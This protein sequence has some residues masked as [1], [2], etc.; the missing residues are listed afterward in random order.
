MVSIPGESLFQH[1]AKSLRVGGPDRRELE[2]HRSKADNASVDKFSEPSYF[3]AFQKIPDA[4]RDQLQQWARRRTS[5]YRLVVRSRIVLL[6]SEGL[7]VAAIAAKLQ[8]AA[9]TVRLWRK[10]FAIG[11]LAALV[12]EAPGRG[13]RS[14]IPRVIVV[15]VL[16][17]TCK[18]A[19]RRLTVRGVAV[20]AGTSA[21]TVWRV[22][23]R[24]A[25]EP[26]SSRDSV[27][28]ILSQVISETSTDNG[29]DSLFA[30]LSNPRW[31]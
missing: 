23:R 27:E 17:A 2:P 29:C 9:A 4:E 25:L 21:S 6:A 1:P 22:W 19:S 13:R 15:A 10:R 7:P 3:G 8:V 18:L 11:G 26:D 28:A 20:Q 14:G 12:S 5:P 31:A 16:E 24:Y 30:S